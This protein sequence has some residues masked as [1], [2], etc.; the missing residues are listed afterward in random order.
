MR[1]DAVWQLVDETYSHWSRH[2]APRLGAAL[3]YYAIFSL[4]PLLIIAIAIAGLVFGHKAA[5]GQIVAQIQDLIGEKGAKAVEMMI[6]SASRPRSGV[7]ATVLGIVTL[8]LGASGVVAELQDALNTIWGVM[9]PGGFS[10]RRLL[11]ERFF[12]FGVVLSTG[13][14]LLVSLLISAGIAAASK[15]VGQALPISPMV[16]QAVNFAASL[17]VVTFLFAV[18]YKV[19]PDTRIAWGDVWVG[20]A[21]TALLFTIGKVL[22]GLYLGRSSVTSVYGAAGTVI[23]IL[24]WVYYSAQIFFIGAEFTQVYACHYGSRCAAQTA[25]RAA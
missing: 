23:L 17:V 24:V 7:V 2:K 1:P 12:L 22:I 3:A 6:E 10:F 14:L 11:R 5:E 15:F 21:V 13:F 20:A 4:A 9:K 8:L 25:R 19:L 18:I 16:L